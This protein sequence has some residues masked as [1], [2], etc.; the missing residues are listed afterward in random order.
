MRPT[1]TAVERDLRGILH[2]DVEFDA[3]TRHLYSTDGGVYQIVPMGVVSPRDAEDVVKIVEY[4]TERGIP[5][6]PRGSGSG[7]A[8]AAVGSGLMVDFTRYMNQVLETAPDGSW[9]RVQPGLVMGALNA[10]AKKYGTF[11]APNPS[12]ENYCS[13]GGMIANNSS[14]GRSVAYGGTKDH[15]LALDVVL[16]GGEL[17]HAGSVGRDSETLGAL[18]AAGSLSGRAFA[19]ILPLLDRKRAAIAAAMPRVMKNCSGYRVENVLEWGASPTGYG[20]WDSSVALAAADDA[21][22][23]AELHKL[24]V[25]SEGTLGLVTEATLNLVPVPQRRAIGMA[26]FPTVFT[27]GEAVQS[28]LGL[29]PTSLEIM[30]ASFLRF[31][32]EANSKIDAMLPAQVDTAL[33]VEFEAAND[34]ELD[35][36]LSQLEGLLAG[37]DAIEV[38]RAL[39]PADQAQLWSVRQGAVPLLQRLPGAKKIVEFIE[40]ATVH[41]D[42]LAQYMSRLSTILQSHGVQAIMYGHAGDGNIHTRPIL[43]MRDPGDLNLM[44]RI[45]EE[46]MEVVIDLKA[47]PSGEHGD[48]L[49]RTPYV[50]R[51][52]GDEVYGVF[53][54]IKNTLDPGGIMNPGKKVA[55]PAE[56]GGIATNLRY[57]RGYWTHE[58]STELHFPSDEYAR[59]IEKCHGCAQCKSV[60]A[61]TMC[62]TYKA[63]RRE[64]ASPRA[65]ANLLRNVI[66]GRLDP[67]ATHTLAA[68]KEITDYCIECGMCALECPSRVNIPKL[69]LEAKAKYRTA[70]M[71]G[72]TDQV[73]GHAELVS[74]VSRAT[75]AVFNPLVGNPVVR[76]LTERVAGIDRRRDLPSYARRSWEQ[77]LAA[78]EKNGGAAAAGATPTSGEKSGTQGKPVAFFYDVYANYN[79]PALAQT[80]ESLLLAHG[81]PVT[82][83]AQKGSAVPEML[84]GY[85][86]RAKATAGYNVRNFAPHVREGELL[87]S[88]EPTASF[89]FKVHYPDITPSEECSLVANATRDLGEFLVSRR[90][91]RPEWAPQPVN[92]IP[93]TVAYH[94]PCHLKTQQIG[95]PFLSLLREVPGLTMVDLDAGCCGMAGTFGMKAGTY[96]LSMETGRP[97]FERVAAV[98]PDLVA[99]E[100]STCRMQ[101]AQATGKDTIHPAELL[102]RAYGI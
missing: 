13:L 88:G 69:M 75:S 40:D 30:D 56:A 82:F 28:I 70:H 49:V 72:V 38:K 23:R 65:K 61:T 20:G 58:Q 47:T 95:S 91:E 32:R 57:G 83:P 25:G 93:L 1:L 7:L 96:D 90:A 98:T 11:F 34:D 9:A 46:V 4:C 44:H 29:K 18:M 33:L 39:D 80:M 48:G 87:V 78:R 84:Y 53:E 42:V 2:G 89:A 35:E 45:M 5:I 19:D 94:Q 43:D 31:V 12:S 6:V 73:L 64:H 10:H 27:A 71:G 85:V 59:E 66:N 14:G 100:C 86:Q 55:N 54:K 79:D 92:E 24:F 3:I 41:P 17:F 52:Y 77:V 51:V 76:R 81:V 102:A 63:T 15:V 8:G 68:T 60:V 97:L 74:R 101:L 16:S 99:S 26:Y 22:A 37:G 50:R 62:P 36:K 21:W 67:Q